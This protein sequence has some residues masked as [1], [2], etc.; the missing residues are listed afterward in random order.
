VYGSF[1]CGNVNYFLL[2]FELQGKR[3]YMMITISHLSSSFKKERRMK[4]MWW[5]ER[6]DGIV[7]SISFPYV[8]TE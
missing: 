1:Y 3:V 7:E 6:G 4:S 2:R 8:A 5:K